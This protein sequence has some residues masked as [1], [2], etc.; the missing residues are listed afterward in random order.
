MIGGTMERLS[1]IGFALITLWLPAAARASYALN[2]NVAFTT[3]SDTTTLIPGGSGAFTG[4]FID[5]TPTDPCIGGG[6]V[7]FFATGLGGQQG[8]YSKLAP[9]DPCRVVADLSTAIPGGAGNFTGFAGA[10]SFSGRVDGFG[11]LS[12]LVFV[13]SRRTGTA[14]SDIVEVGCSRPPSDEAGRVHDL[15]LGRDRSSGGRARQEYPD[16]EEEP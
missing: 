12:A 2:F 7:S 8:I 13:T 1:S 9:V 16:H 11:L 14:P 5:L 3:V 4:F 6:H 10:P 15:S